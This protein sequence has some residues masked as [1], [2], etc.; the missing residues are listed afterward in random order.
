MF[1]CCLYFYLTCTAS[2]G[3]CRCFS[4]R[5]KRNF[6]AIGVT[7]DEI[8][9]SRITGVKY[10]ELIIPQDNPFCATIS[11]TSPRVIIPTPTFRESSH[12]NRH[13]RAIKEQPM[14][15]HSNATSTK[16]TANSTKSPEMA[17]SEVLSP[18]LAK[19]T[20]PNSI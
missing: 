2:A 13:T 18:I 12:L 16:P 4:S 6:R 14:I 9:I 1:P 20:G 10:A 3:G 15:L 5:A 7:M 11:A 17:S 8:R 19:N